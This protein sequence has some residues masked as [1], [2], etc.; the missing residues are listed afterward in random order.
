M[1]YPMKIA[2]Q[3]LATL[4]LPV[5]LSAQQ[6]AAANPERG[7]VQSVITEFGRL[8]E[9]GDLSK[10]DSF[11]PPRGHILSDNAT[12]HS[13]VEFRDNHFKPE[14]ARFPMLRYAHTA[15]EAV[16]RGDIAWVAFRRELSSGAAGGP[17]A[18]SGRGTAV[19]E[20]REGT[21]VIVHMH[22]SS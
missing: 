18:V 16:V 6:P 17:A 22:M 9:A 2:G 11:F 5:A 14:L 3:L 21:W 10:L 7:A 13:W 20:K 8:V 19:L 4:L 1:R 12:T 15:V